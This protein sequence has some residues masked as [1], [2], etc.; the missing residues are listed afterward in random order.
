[1]ADARDR[2]ARALGTDNPLVVDVFDGA[3]ALLGNVPASML[4]ATV[5]HR[6]RAGAREDPGAA[7]MS[8][9][10]V[11]GLD[12]AGQP[13][14]VTRAV[15]LRLANAALVAL[16]G[17]SVSAD[18][19]AARARFTGQ[20]S[21]LG[22]VQLVADSD[23]MQVPMAAAGIYAR[24]STGSTVGLVPWPAGTSDV[25]ILTQT[26]NAAWTNDPGVRVA[27]WATLANR[28]KWWAPAAAR[29]PVDAAR[30]FILWDVDQQAPTQI[31]G[32]LIAATAG[33]V[34]EQ[35]DGRLDWLT[36]ESRRAAPVS[37]S[38]DASQILAPAVA[39][40][41]LADLVDQATIT[42]GDPAASVVVVDQAAI[43]DHGVYPAPIETKLA[44]AAAAT[45]RATDLVGRYGWPLWQLP[46]ITVDLTQL[47]EDGALATV[48]ALLMAESGSLVEITGLPTTSPVTGGLFWV[49]GTD[50]SITA[51]RW[52]LSLGLVA[53]P[54]LAPPIRW[55]EVPASLRW[56]DVPA[57]VSWIGATGY[58]PDPFPDSSWRT[59][60][61]NLRWSQL[62]ATAWAD[63]T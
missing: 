4:A 63:Y 61:A 31:V 17:S 13:L 27:E 34:V 16:F 1:M 25:D 11:G 15:R 52:Q 56:V 9:V 32:D 38:L 60:P 33:V 59:L 30:R 29:T 40:Q 23:T 49:E 21:D 7:T 55:G 3:G 47:I 41:N 5:V 26:L 19:L 62:P 24:L 8:T 43:D 50:E 35:R 58:Q 53:Y 45:D 39:R 36:P 10:L 51:K 6:G 46:A 14:T 28:A 42:W 22:D 12:V 2:L 48:R 44:S 37:V 57:T 54:L 20:I 18:A